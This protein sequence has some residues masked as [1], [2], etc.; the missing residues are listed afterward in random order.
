MGPS[1][2]HL[3]TLRG[4]LETHFFFKTGEIETSIFA[5]QER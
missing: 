1:R 5:K 3:E 4:H 2:G